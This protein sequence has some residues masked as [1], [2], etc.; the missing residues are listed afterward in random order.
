MRE[1]GVR[2]PGQV[3]VAAATQHSSGLC[4][5]MLSWPS[6]SLAACVACLGC[7]LLLLGVWQAGSAMESATQLAIRIHGPAGL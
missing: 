5:P 6:L 3:S 1:E 4:W 7:F 2:S